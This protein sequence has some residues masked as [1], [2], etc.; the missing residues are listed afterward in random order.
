MKTPLSRNKSKK[1]RRSKGGER[2]HSRRTRVKKYNTSIGTRKW[3]RKVNAIQMHDRGTES[4]IAL[5]TADNILG[6]ITGDSTTSTTIS[7]DETI[8]EEINKDDAF[9]IL[10]INIHGD[11]YCKKQ[12]DTLEPIVSKISPEVQMLNRIIF[13]IPGYSDVAHYNINLKYDKIVE[14]EIKEL[15]TAPTHKAV[16]GDA[17]KSELDDLGVVNYKKLENNKTEPI[18]PQYDPFLFRSEMYVNNSVQL[19]DV[20][21][22]L[23]M[24][25]MYNKYDYHS[26]IT[27][28]YQQNGRLREGDTIFK[29]NLS[30]FMEYMTYNDE[31]IKNGEYY[32]SI[33]DLVDLLVDQGYTKIQLIDFTC[34]TF[35]DDPEDERERRRLTRNLLRLRR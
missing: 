31:S 29:R 2:H 4:M 6:D 34:E 10:L 35:S 9:I 13:T 12:F 11:I 27:V 14:D 22:K 5:Q 20:P 23:Y 16:Y 33:K 18:P 15:I 32:I 28:I 8:P 19:R 7:N 21:K 30:R 26:D 1:R 17:L 25:G 3:Q 24:T